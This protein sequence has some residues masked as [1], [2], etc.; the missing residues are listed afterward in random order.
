MLE[1]ADASITLR[2]WLDVVRRAR[3]G[4][5]PKA[6]ALMLATYADND[7][8]RVFPS[9]TRLAVDRRFITPDDQ[10]RPGAA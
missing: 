3:L 5:T 7:G 9:V 2:Q 8:R 6:V 10:V 1:H 4:R